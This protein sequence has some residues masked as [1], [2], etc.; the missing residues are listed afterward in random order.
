M[1]QSRFCDAASHRRALYGRDGYSR[2]E[3][4]TRQL[5]TFGQTALAQQQ[6]LLYEKHAYFCIITPDTVTGTA[7]MCPSFVPGTAIP[8]YSKDGTWLQTVTLI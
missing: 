6:C 5:T 4:V 3:A 8:D 1:G 2:P 7:S